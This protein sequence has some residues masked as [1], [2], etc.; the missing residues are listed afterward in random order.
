M[1]AS[2]RSGHS[3]FRLSK[4]RLSTAFVA[5]RAARST[6]LDLTV[7]L[8]DPAKRGGACL[9]D[10]SPILP[11]PRNAPPT[12]VLAGSSARALARA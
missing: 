3:D 12:G 5:S 4:F 2:T 9:L 1:T 8:A 6:K 7:T 10:I 11:A